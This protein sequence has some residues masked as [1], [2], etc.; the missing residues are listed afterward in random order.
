MGRLE[1]EKGQPFD[2][3][4]VAH[5]NTEHAHIHIVV[6][7]KDPDGGRVRLDLQD[8]KSL[9]EFG[10]RYLEREHKL[11]RYLDRE[12]ERVLKEP[13]KGIQLDSKRAKGDG[14]FER[15]MYGDGDERDHRR[16]SKETER[17]RQE[18]ERMDKDLHRAYGDERFTG[19]T[20]TYKQ[21][22][23]ESSGR[24][25]RFHQDY[26]NRVAR[27]RWLDQAKDNPEIAKEIAKEL[28]WLQ[29]LEKEQRMDR[30]KDVDIDRLIDGKDK[31]ERWLDR[32]F[33]TGDWRSELDIMNSA[34]LR[35]RGA[36]ERST[37]PMGVFTHN[38]P[39]DRER[40]YEIDLTGFADSKQDFDKDREAQSGTQGQDR[41]ERDKDERKRGDDPFGR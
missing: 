32:I 30:Y 9:R 22:Q 31:H 13:Y 34:Q 18:W 36:Q 37:N 25:D 4:A 21:Y 24:W 29:E 27:E 3:F 26:Q 11:E 39:L 8:M 10:D 20:R 28:F 23:M 38:E 7:G 40:G 1:R 35:E 16:S 14:E 19:R 5:R 17:D 15:L 41:D 33:E 6:M 12:I 2:W